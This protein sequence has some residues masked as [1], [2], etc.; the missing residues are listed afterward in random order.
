MKN[1][2]EKRRHQRVPYQSLINF[3]VLSMHESEFRRI[4]FDGTI[5]DVS[6]DGIGIVTDF[7][8]QPGQVVQ[9]DDRH[10]RNRLHIGI[11]KWSQKQGDLYRA[12]VMFLLR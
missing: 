12:G 4:Q 5:M 1:H 7:S 3:T 8:L 10:K 11:V 2:N 6:E 9:W